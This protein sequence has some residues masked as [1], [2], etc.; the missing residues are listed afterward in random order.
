MNDRRILIF[1]ALSATVAALTVGLVPLFVVG[2]RWLVVAGAIAAGLVIAIGIVSIWQR[3]QPAPETPRA[4]VLLA[5]QRHDAAFNE[6]R[7]GTDN[8]ETAGLAYRLGAAFEAASRHDLAERTWRLIAERA[9]YRAHRAAEQRTARVPTL[10]K[11]SSLPRVIGRYSIEGLLGRG[12][13]GAVYLAIDTRLNRSVALKV[14]NLEREFDATGL[15][16]ARARFFQEAESAGRLHHPAVATVFDAG[17][18]GSLA[19]IAM[20]YVT[21]RPLSDFRYG[22]EPM[23]VAQ[24]VELIARAAEA[25]A[26]AHEQRVIHR[27][28]KPSNLLYDA[29]TDALKIMDFG[30]AQLSDVV[31]TRTGIILGTPVYMA[32]EQLFG[33]PI[34]GYSDLFS[35]GVT[36]YELLTGVLPFPANKLSDVARAITGGTVR[37]LADHRQELPESLQGV[38]DR[39]LAKAPRER[40]QD[41]WTMA[42]ALRECLLDYR[43]NVVTNRNALRCQ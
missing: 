19:Y 11:P 27:D 30:V 6:L 8:G 36:L 32:P 31:R 9:E 12:A 26:Y 7:A 13:M 1:S 41:G 35:L 25:L 28:V 17:E 40:Y 4:A 2:P 20:E 33:E 24:L 43:T 22:D 15:D 14:V 29:D 10:A 5:Q 23:D 3:R 42:D 39:A 18:V 16:A 38:V 34:G 21:G 37:P